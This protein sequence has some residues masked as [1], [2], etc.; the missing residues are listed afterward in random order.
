[1]KNRAI[2]FLSTDTGR[3]TALAVA[4]F[5]LAFGGVVLSRI[6]SASMLR[7]DA[8]STSSAWASTLVDSSDDI[9]EMIAGAAPSS[10][11]ERLLNET[12]Q[13]GDI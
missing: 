2:R 4:I 11:T 9:P 6:V 5:L 10:K 8:Q 7:A 13:V 1:V 3:I 12:I